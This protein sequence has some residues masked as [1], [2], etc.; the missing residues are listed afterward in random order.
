[1][2]FALIYG[3]NKAYF[4]SKGFNCI[5][6]LCLLIAAFSGTRTALIAIFVVY[7]LSNTESFK[8]IS[9]VIVVVFVTFVCLAS[10]L[11]LGDILSRLSL[12]VSTE[13]PRQYYFAK[14]LEVWAG[15][16]L[17][18][19]GFGTF[20]TLRYR[21]LTQDYIFDSY[22]IHKFDFAGLT[23][24]DSFFSE[25]IPEFGLVGIAVLLF[26]VYVVLKSMKENK[27]YAGAISPTLIAALV[28][29][30][31]SSTAFTSPH[32]GFYFWFALGLMFSLGNRDFLQKRSS[33]G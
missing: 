19:I 21:D 3:V 29:A 31:N 23:S 17:F 2:V 9:K 28:L 11:P 26:F 7:V 33:L 32:V 5:C 27:P 14:G 13:L 24:T 16:P 25:V 8:E 6:S 4:K 18:G 10:F 20:G 12:D 30:V 22:D 1:M 15:H